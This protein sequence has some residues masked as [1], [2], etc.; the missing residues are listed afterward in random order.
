MTTERVR[1][2]YRDSLDLLS[3]LRSRLNDAQSW[4]PFAEDECRCTAFGSFW[5]AIEKSAN[6]LGDFHDTANRL[7]DNA[8][9]YYADLSG[10]SHT[11]PKFPVVNGSIPDPRRTLAELKR[12][13]RLGQTDPNFA[14]I[15][16]HRESRKVMIAGFTSLGQAINNVGLRIENSL[17]RL[18]DSM[19]S[20]SALIVEQM[21][22]SRDAYENASKT[23][24]QNIE[25]A[26]N[27]SARALNDL[28]KDS[29]RNAE[30][31]ARVLDN[32][33]R[34][35]KPSIMDDPKW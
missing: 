34:G 32:I 8:V 2:N 23:I 33:Q 4:L 12:I 30:E 17:D 10:R 1:H 31:Q 27:V 29:A 25:Q 7:A 15:W 19:S 11:F 6:I 21:I 13:T 9:R 24:G 16:E 20:H 18:E 26:G 14:N 3:R 22:E 28:K 5:D 35:R